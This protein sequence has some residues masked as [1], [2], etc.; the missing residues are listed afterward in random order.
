MN[1]PLRHAVLFA[2]QFFVVG[3]TLPFLPAVLA[4][5]GLTPTEVAAALATGSALRLVAGPLGGRLADALGGPRGLLAA[6]A[7]VAALAASGLLVASGFLL[8]LLSYAA[9]SIAMAPIV[10]LT[11]AAAVAASRREGF[12]YGRV[13][14][15][16]SVSFILAALLAGQVVGAFGTQAA[17]PMIVAGLLA[18]SLAAL[19]LPAAPR[20][21]AARRGGLAG[22]LAPL[23]IRGFPWLL[24]VSA[25]VQGSHAFYYAF[26]TLHWRAAGLGDGLIGALWATGVIA[27]IALFFWGRGVATRLGPVGLSLVAAGAGVIRWGALALTTDPLLLFPLQV[28]HGATFGAQHL[29][30]MM[31]LGRIVPPAQ[32]ATA[33]TLHAALGVG[34]AT[35][36]LTFASGPLYA[37]FGGGGYLAMALLCALA[38]PASL[39]LGAALTR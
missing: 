12:D 10:P 39:A 27:E 37:S 38:V 30:A 19:A 1:Q 26:G 16:G 23:R 29:A 4:A 11:D 15:A 36:A 21:P 14:S 6:G 9:M 3:V 5:R 25:L 17:T 28:L 22:F 24:L 32:A 8:V 35:G 13:R 33:Q 34:F 31:V 7:A 18:T 20:H 2:A